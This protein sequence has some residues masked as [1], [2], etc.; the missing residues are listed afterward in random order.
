MKFTDSGKVTVRIEFRDRRLHA[1]ISDTGCGIDLDRLSELREPFVQ[2]DLST[3]KEYAGFGLGLALCDMCIQTL[4][5]KLEFSSNDPVGT[6]AY[7][8]FPIVSGTIQEEEDCEEV[9]A[10]DRSMP[11]L[12]VEDNPGKAKENARVFLSDNIVS[13]LVTA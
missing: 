12:L 2:G 11:D 3:T 9:V 4:G 5:G 10:V 1:R 6:T 13:T 8:H 7:F